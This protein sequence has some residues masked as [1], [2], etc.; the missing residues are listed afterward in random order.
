M[1]PQAGC[2]LGDLQLTRKSR[3]NGSLSFQPAPSPCIDEFKCCCADTEVEEGNGGRAD[4]PAQSPTEPPAPLPSQPT[5]NRNPAADQEG[6]PMRG[7]AVEYGKK[8]CDGLCIDPDDNDTCCKKYCNAEVL[9]D[10]ND[11]S[12]EIVSCGSEHCTYADQEPSCCDPTTH[13]WCDKIQK[14]GEAGGECIAKANL[15]TVECVSTCE[16]IDNDGSTSGGAPQQALM[17]SSETS[18]G[19]ALGLA[20]CV[21]HFS[22]PLDPNGPDE[23]EW[24]VRTCEWPPFTNR[25]PRRPRKWPRK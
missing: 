14:C 19:H 13:V 2:A 5:I 12:Q 15:H 23:A 11:L 16:V 18:R 4:L 3:N 22:D 6:I 8:W 17:C 10:P 9:P 7:C 25:V 20:E 24:I 1:A 21:P